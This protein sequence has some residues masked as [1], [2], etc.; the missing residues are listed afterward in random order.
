M[1]SRQAPNRKAIQVR[2]TSSDEIGFC[3]TGG[4]TA[5]PSTCSWARF[6]PYPPRLVGAVQN[7]GDRFMRHAAATATADPHPDQ[8]ADRG[9][10]RESG[11]R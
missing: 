4:G 11:I 6:R 9:K 3:R 1:N 7:E 8:Q 10:D 5:L 2:Q